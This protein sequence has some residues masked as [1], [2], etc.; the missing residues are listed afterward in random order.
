[1]E[2]TTLSTPG[3]ALPQAASFTVSDTAAARIVFLLSDEKPGTVFRISVAGGGCSGFSY[4]FDLDAKGAAESDLVIER[5]GAKVAID[6]VSIGML[7]GSELDY[8]EDLSGAG[9]SVKN[10]NATAKCGCGNSF[11]V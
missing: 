4:V 5:G 10:P 8:A 11:G 1:M 3:A 2:N 6:D 9:F 7:A